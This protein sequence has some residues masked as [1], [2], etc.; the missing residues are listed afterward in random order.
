MHL[1]FTATYNDIKNMYD[2]GMVDDIWGAFRLCNIF[3]IHLSYYQT[4]RSAWQSFSSDMIKYHKETRFS[5][6]SRLEGYNVCTN[7]WC[8]C[9]SPLLSICVLIY[10][11]YYNSL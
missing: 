4:E 9:S 5:G 6:L 7:M 8:K 11:L 2:K 10:R 3:S 1:V